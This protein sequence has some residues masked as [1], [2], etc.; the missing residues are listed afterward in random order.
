MLLPCQQRRPPSRMPTCSC[1]KL[2]SALAL[3]LR[4][5]GLDEYDLYDYEKRWAGPLSPSTRT[6]RPA[7]GRYAAS[8]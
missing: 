7:G 2:S 4:T 6:N 5:S 3:R 1:A 8:V